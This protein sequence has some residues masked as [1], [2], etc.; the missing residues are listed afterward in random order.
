MGIGHG[1]FTITLLLHSIDR[2][3]SGAAEKLLPLV[4]DELR[5]RAGIL[6]SGERR[7]HTLQRTALVHEAYLKLAGSRQGFRSRLEFFSAAALAMR[8]ILVDHATR[9]KSLKRGGGRDRVDV[10]V[11]DIAEPPSNQTLDWLELDG[12]LKTL[13]QLSPRQHQ[14]V[15]LRFFSGRTEA[16]I[17]EMLQISEATVRRE[18]ATARMWLFRTMR[19]NND[20]SAGQNRR[21]VDGDA[22]NEPG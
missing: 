19:Q 22:A 20:R 6:M 9:R 3:E 17:A 2:G 5:A 15:M 16:E 11:M 10:E 14:I 4:Y 8:R 13:E 18:W 12:V 1:R 7:D 21:H